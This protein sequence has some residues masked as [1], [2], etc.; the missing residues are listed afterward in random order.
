MK[1]NASKKPI[2]AVPIGLKKWFMKAAYPEN[3]T[4][5]HD[6]VEI[7]P[8]HPGLDEFVELMRGEHEQDI[9][10][11]EPQESKPKLKLVYSKGKRQP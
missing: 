3:V 7:D 1:N 6:V 8:T 11:E 2:L 10:Q 4:P 5:L 9:L